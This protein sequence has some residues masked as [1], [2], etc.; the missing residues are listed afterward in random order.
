M[1]HG[2]IKIRKRLGLYPLTGIDNKECSS[3]EDSALDYFISKINMAG[4]VN[5]FQK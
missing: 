5:Q 1:F 3:Q 4:S 2:Q